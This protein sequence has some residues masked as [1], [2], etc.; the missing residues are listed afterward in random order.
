[1]NYLKL[2][3]SRK[4]YYAALFFSLVIMAFSYGQKKRSFV[5]FDNDP[6]MILNRRAGQFEHYQIEYFSKKSATIYLEL[7]DK[8]DKVVANSI[9]ELKGRKKGRKELTIRLFPESKLKPSS[10]YKY[11][12]SMYEAPMHVWE[13][14]V[15]SI[16]IAGVKVTSKI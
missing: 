13:N 7:V 15:T 6:A 14:L 3:K 10:N 12:L 5:K 11:R 9:L 4:K 16:E 8:Y 1:M 2:S